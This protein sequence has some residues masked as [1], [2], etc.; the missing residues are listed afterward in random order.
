MSIKTEN[1]KKRMLMFLDTETSGIPIRKDF[2][3]YHHYSKTQYY[4]SS[5]IVQFSY[6][7]YELYEDN[8]F[9]HIGDYDHIIKP[10]DFYVTEESANVH[11]ISHERAMKEGMPLEQFWDI[12]KYSL[13]KV[14]TII[15]HN[16]DFDTNVIKSEMFRS[17][18]YD[19]LDEFNKK[20][21]ICTMKTTKDLVRSTGAFGTLKPPRLAEL[22]EYL[23]KKK[24]EEE[25][26]HNSLYDTKYM[27]DCFIE[28]VNMGYYKLKNFK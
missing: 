7:L 4:D 27:A 10:V 3:N 25:N 22:Y 21:V 5:R 14:D 1:R 28:L 8:E 15:A 6:I 11:G 26:L 19:L 2:H 18:R 23:F 24:P 17:G 12:F 13:K 9:V 16:S 20:R